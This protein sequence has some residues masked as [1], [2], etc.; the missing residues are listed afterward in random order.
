MY[1]KEIEENYPGALASQW[2]PMDS[3]LWTLERY[4][5]F[6][7]E[8]RKLLA[9]AA[10][11]FLDTL[12]MGI[13]RKVDYPTE[14]IQL[15]TAAVG[16]EDNE[17]QALVSWAIARGFPKPELNFEVSDLNTGEVLIIVDAAWPKGLQEEYSPPIALCLE[18]DEQK[19]A[20]LNQA[21]YRF[22]ISIEA[23]RRYLKEQIDN[24]TKRV[25]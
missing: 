19:I 22:F 13:P 24:G 16:E 4:K 20:I 5:D 17:L 14:S 8:R 11:T 9:D 10:N 25:A 6:L 2:I 21:G 3:T 1:F 18:A 15:A 23:L 7:V 12:I